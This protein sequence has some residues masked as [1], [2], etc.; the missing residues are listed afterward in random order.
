MPEEKE[1]LEIL[2]S[3][4][5]NSLVVSRVEASSGP[6][7]DEPRFTMLETIREYAAERLGSGGEAEEM[8]CAHAMYYL[9]LAEAAQPEV[10]AQMLKEWVVILEQEHDNLRAALRW[11]IRHREVDVGTR[12]GLMLWR[13]W[14][15]RYHVSEGRRWMEL[16]LALGEPEG[17][18]AEPSMA[19]RRWAFLHLVTGI[20]AAGQGDHDRATELY[21]E[22]LALYTNMGHRKGT[23]GPLR[24]LG[25]TAYHRGDYKRAVR[26]NQ[27]ALA[28]T[29]EFGSTFGSGLTI[30]TLSDALRAQGDLEQ[31]K[32]LLE[33][34]LPSLR[35]QT[36]PLRVANALAN[37]LGRLGSIE[38]EMGRVA[39][40]SELYTESL[41]LARRFGFT[42]DAVISLEG[43]AR[44][45]A[46]QDRPEGAA[47]LLGAS[48]ALREELEHAS[49][50]YRPG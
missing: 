7:D 3:L 23:S 4:V 36:Y 2:A 40:A 13:F 19:A 30:C 18:V 25:V 20:L 45:V 47:R 31:A 50:A 32:T 26:L 35:R 16:V 39:R 34:S 44:V 11:A 29:R 28:I 14:P 42:Y 21:E 9:A 15:E 24:Q 48:A 17:G 37:T 1:V 43:M 38:C 27:Q 12:L 8:H 33:E 5:D 22:S 49:H 41:N 6:G 46:L 10:S